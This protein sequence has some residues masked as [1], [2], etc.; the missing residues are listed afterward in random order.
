[1]P[2]GLNRCLADYQVYQS[3]L[4]IGPIG[5]VERGGEEFDDPNFP[6]IA[7]QAFSLFFS[8]YIYI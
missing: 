3:V 8:G 2:S 7:I 5:G 1:L 6:H 4:S